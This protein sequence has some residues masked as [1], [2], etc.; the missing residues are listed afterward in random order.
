M[1]EQGTRHWALDLL[2]EGMQ[3]LAF[4]FPSWFFRLLTKIPMAAEGYQKFVQ[5][6][7]DELTW[8]V[9]NDAEATS[10]GGKRH[11][12]TTYKARETLANSNLQ[13]VFHPKGLRRDR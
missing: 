8:R 9:K 2:N 1:L 13:Y 6:C 3:P 11:V 5:F 4:F 10:K 12:S 7:R